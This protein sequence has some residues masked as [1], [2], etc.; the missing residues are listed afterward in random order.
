MADIAML[1]AEEYERRVNNLRKLAAE[2]EMTIKQNNNAAP[3]TATAAA[4]TAEVVNVFDRGLMGS[5][6]ENLSSGVLE[7]KSQITLAA[8]DG[9]FS[10]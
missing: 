3:A 5:R 8:F 1:V 2:R 4:T 7:P 6:S 9:F 10:A